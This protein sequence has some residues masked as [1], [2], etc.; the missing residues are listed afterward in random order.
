M[1]SGKGGFN[2][3][4]DD[5]V[6]RAENMLA[7][8]PAVDL[9]QAAAKRAVAT[10]RPAATNRPSATN[11]QSALTKEDQKPIVL[12]RPR[13]HQVGRIERRSRA[14]SLNPAG[15]ARVAIARC[16][17]SNALGVQEME[18][19]DEQ[20]ESGRDDSGRRRVVRG[21]RFT[22]RLRVLLGLDTVAVLLAIGA[23]IGAY[24]VRSPQR[25][26]SD[27]EPVSV[28][29]K[30]VAQV[31][32]SS[33]Q[34]RGLVYP[35]SEYAVYA[36]APEAGSSSAVSSGG[37]TAPVDVTKLD[38]GVGSRITNGEQ[39]AEIGG[40]P[41]FALTGPVPARRGLLPG[42]SGADVAELQ[43]ALASLGY[44]YDGDIPGYFGPATEDAVALYYEHLGFAPPSTGGVPLTDVVFFGSLPATVVGVNRAAG[45][46]AGQPFLEVAP[47]GSLAL[48]GELSPADAGQVKTGLKVRIYD[49]VTGIRSTGTV[50]SVAP[51]T[52]T[53]P[54]GTVVDVGA[55]AASASSQSGSAIS[56]ST[57][58]A[59]SGSSGSAAAAP[60]VPLVV[61]PSRPLPAALNGENVLVTVETGRTEG[62][63]LTVPVAAVVTTASGKSHVT[64]V[65]G[66]GKQTEVTVTVGISGNRY[67][68]V[69]P[70]RPGALAAGDRVVVT[71]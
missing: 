39:L 26:V 23:L 55:G 10:N 54:A 20:T 71:A 49:E 47:R 28:T 19:E 30:V 63:V 22:Q 34:M 68:Q 45:D 18:L 57:R 58:S 43:D 29:A 60:F 14:A 46:Q 11:G 21:S 17:N 25:L 3:M 59:E 61:R 40:E 24:F 13:R 7:H 67:V 65:A 6:R 12:R 5:A 1:L 35:S 53:A 70:A 38:V 33:V 44:Y 41:M 36:S 37:G 51:A 16:R 62:A 42:E 15:A 56:A 48:T 4:V 8:G 27:T 9:C 2:A 66:A 52:T 50:V 69:T 31:L 64:V 32:T